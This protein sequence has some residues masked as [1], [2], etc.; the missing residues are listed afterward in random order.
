MIVP[1]HLGT[2]LYGKVD[3]VPGLFHVA[4]RFWHLNYI[5]LVPVESL[6]VF[7][8]KSFVKIENEI[9]AV[10]SPDILIPLNLRSVLFAWLRTILLVVST[11]SSFLTALFVFLVCLGEIR[12]NE[13]DWLVVV[14]FAMISVLLFTI[15]YFS[16]RFT[17]AGPLRALELA[18]M[19][20]I[21]PEEVA[22]F[23][24]DRESFPELQEFGDHQGDSAAAQ[25]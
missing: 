3:Q 16:Y 14:A 7:D 25:E 6:I 5:P 15:L 21:S 17:R 9:R 11:V 10:H 8:K 18:R 23:F 22:Q 2:S 13:D 24:V 19:A 20:D 4:T 1:T 12:M